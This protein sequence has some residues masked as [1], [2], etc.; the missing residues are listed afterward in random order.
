MEQRSEV[1]TEHATSDDGTR[2]IV[3]AHQHFWDPARNY[4]P[5]L[6]DEPPIRFATATIVRSAG[7]TCHRIISP[8]PCR[9]AS[10]KRVCRDGMGS[11]DPIGETRY[12]DRLRREYGLPS[13]VVAQ[14]WLHRD[15]A[16]AILA[17][18]RVCFRAQRPPQATR[19]RFSLRRRARRHD[20]RE[21]RAGFAVSRRTACGS[22]C[23]RRGGISPRRRA[24]PP[25][26]PTRRSSSITPAC[27][28]TAARR[29]CRLEARDG[30]AC[31]RPNVAVKIS[32]LGQPGQPWTAAANRDIV[33]TMI[34]L[35][36][37]RRCMFASNFPVDSL[38]AS[39]A[40]I[41]GG[42]REIVRDFSAAEQRALFHDN[43]I[44]V[45]EMDEAHGPPDRLRRCRPDGPADGQAPGVARLRGPRVRH[46]AAQVD[47]ARAA[48]ATRR[49]AGRGG[50][51]RRLVLLNLP[52]TDAV[53]QAVFGA[54]GV[55]SALR[56]RNSSSTSRPSRSSG[57]ARSRRG[58]TPRP[59]A[60]GSTRR[61]P[62]VLPHPPP[63]R[64]PSWRAATRPTSRASRR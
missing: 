32:G 45:Y 8:T 40:T 51:R 64:S 7:V 21:W 6:R 12:V 3:D 33:R 37:V 57:A 61:S 48:G 43:A 54:D 17:A 47:A 35:F 58:C 25:I 49:I 60:G 44:R 62:A 2:D 27:R 10:R 11:R 39:F 36:G 38:C 19:Q 4:H 56:R 31:A 52:T 34:D 16:P 14:A 28:P 63:A 26:F 13:V 23:R 53:E 18:G 29:H 5:W 59:A 55:A 46:R 22:T 20:R 1:G 24:L 41:F 50:A 9:I 42:F 15:D 30:D